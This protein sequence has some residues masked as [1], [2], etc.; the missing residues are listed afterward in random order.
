MPYSLALEKY[1]IVDWYEPLILI[2]PIS[3]KKYLIRLKID[4]AAQNIRTEIETVELPQTVSASSSA[5][6][7]MTEVEIHFPLP[8]RD[9]REGEEYNNV[10]KGISETIE[11]LKH[12]AIFNTHVTFQITVHLSYD[13]DKVLEFPAIQPLNKK[14]NNLPSIH[15]YDYKAFE[16][17]IYTLDHNGD[18]TDSQV[19]LYDIMRS[20]FKEA[21]NMRRDL[22][23]CQTVAELKKDVCKIHALF[24]ELKKIAH[25]SAFH[26]VAN[27]EL[28][29][30]TKPSARKFALAKRIEQGYDHKYQVQDIKYL[31][32]IDRIDHGSYTMENYDNTYSYPVFFEITIATVKTF[33]I[34]NNFGR[35]LIK[36]VNN[37][38][39]FSS[40]AF[41]GDYA[42]TFRW[43]DDKEQ[44]TLLSTESQTEI[45]NIRFEQASGVDE[46][47]TKMGY[48]KY[49]KSNYAGKTIV[50]KKHNSIILINLVSPIIKYENYGKSSFE[51]DPFENIIADTIYA[52]CKKDKNSRN[53]ISQSLYDKQKKNNING[54][55][56][57]KQFTR[58]MLRERLK[59]IRLDPTIVR[60]YPWTVRGISYLVKDRLIKAGREEETI[61][62]DTISG[63]VKDIVEN[64]MHLKRK[65]LGI[66]AAQRAQLY[67]DGETHPVT[68]DDIEKLADYGTDLI[69]IEKE[70]IALSLTYY[71]DEAGFAILNT[72]GFLVEYAETL[73]K[74]AHEKGCNVVILTDF[75]VY[76]LRIV[77]EQVPWIPRIGIDF[78]TLKYFGLSRTDPTIQNKL[79]Q[80]DLKE[81]AYKRLRRI[82]DEHAGVVL[83]NF[84]N[85]HGW[86]KQLTIDDNLAVYGPLLSEIAEYLRSNRIE[87]NAILA[88]V[89]PEKFWK[90]IQDKVYALHRTR[91]YNRAIARPLADALDP[92]IV[93]EFKELFAQ[94]KTLITDKG[95]NKFESEFQKV[96]GF[97]DV[98]KRRQEIKDK[99]MQIVADNKIVK[100][101]I[102]KISSEINTILKEALDNYRHHYHSSSR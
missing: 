85:A 14:W 16:N 24:T 3:R 64:E 65:A 4:K 86:P 38:A 101:V 100:Q 99:L 69:I 80:S 25:S 76:G 29:F 58:D 84:C 10:I 61:D 67:F 83:D 27:F 44:K 6:P 17:L 56:I 91:N 68:A 51:L 75:D 28:P 50:T 62:Q 72:R 95:Y 63:Y 73:S 26:D 13:D 81:A 7:K 70:D 92:E 97:I 89:R 96:D 82:F 47:L 90:Y 1:Q 102:K 60:T 59:E 20:L 12:T 79:S 98:P 18:G 74:L 32:H 41:E 40:A 5:L 43:M 54:I 36:S 77:F 94:L 42:D 88:K 53:K 87:L 52:L 31:N 2:D 37:S 15:Y 21:T 33:D 93:I 39:R 8:S 55:G 34:K 46:M 11:Q 49:S 66:Y 9:L 48:L 19:L 23:P 45:A 78:E 22:M 30:D 35:K 71:A 57:I